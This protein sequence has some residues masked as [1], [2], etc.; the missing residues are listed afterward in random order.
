VLAESAAEIDQIKVTWEGYADA[1]TQVELYVWNNALGNWGDANGLVGQNRYLDSFA[2]NRDER[3]DARIR[4][5]IANY[6]AADGSIRFLVYGERQND[7][8]FH[9]YMSVTV[10]RVD[11]PCTGD[12]DGD[13]AVNGNDLATLLGSWGTCAGCAGDLNGDGVIDGN[14]LASVLGSWG[15]CP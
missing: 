10:M 8:T 15:A 6:V 1:C 5:N 9:D 4:N 14:D 7:R 13:G 2:G 11:A 12:V 3:L